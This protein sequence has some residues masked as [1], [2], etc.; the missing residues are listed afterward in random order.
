[1]VMLLC[2]LL[3]P[4]L[5][6]CNDTDDVQKI[7]TG[8]TWK[9]TNI[10]RGKKDQGRWFAFPGVSDA[11]YES[12][13]PINGS[14][15]FRLSFEGST[16]DDVISGKFNSVSPSSITINGT[17]SA[18]ARSNEF[19]AD[20][21]KSSSSNGDTLGKFIIE[22]VQKATSYGGDE[23]NLYLYYEYEKEVLYIAFT[24]ER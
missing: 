9:M 10:T 11:V 20:I 17:W 24:P 8:K 7:F 21:E 2:I 16:L 4:V 22:A 12:Y 1:M 15:A 23:N 14:R 3:I 6:G 5:S 13:D 19:H 18:N